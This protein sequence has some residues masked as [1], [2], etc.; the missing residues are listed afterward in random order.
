ML[1]I[2]SDIGDAVEVRW[3]MV[4]PSLLCLPV[5]RRRTYPSDFPA[6]LSITLRRETRADPRTD[7]YPNP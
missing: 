5:G 3:G 2:E 7:S 4:H 6:S 1:H